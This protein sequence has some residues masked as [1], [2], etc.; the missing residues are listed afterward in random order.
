MIV[1]PR[2]IQLV[3]EKTPISQGEDSK[4]KNKVVMEKPCSL[5]LESNI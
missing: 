4:K 2:K 5:P 1:K 3:K